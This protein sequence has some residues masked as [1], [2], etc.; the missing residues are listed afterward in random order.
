MAVGG[1]LLMNAAAPSHY[2][3]HLSGRLKLGMVSIG[4]LYHKSCPDPC[5]AVHGRAPS[6]YTVHLSGRGWDLSGR[7]WDSFEEC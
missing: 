4:L 5:V 1:I 3:V 6:Y 2:T 7:G